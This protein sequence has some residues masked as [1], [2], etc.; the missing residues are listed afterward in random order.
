M[1][2]SDELKRASDE[3]EATRQLVE[4]LRAKI[5]A[6]ERRAKA[7]AEAVRLVD[8]WLP[9]FVKR[10]E[11]VEK[12]IPLHA[13]EILQRA[14]KAQLASI[15]KDAADL[16][17]QVDAVADAEDA[18][19]TAQKWRIRNALDSRIASARSLIAEQNKESVAITGPLAKANKALK[20][21]AKALAAGELD[22]A[23]ASLDD[24]EK[25]AQKARA[26]LAAVTHR[27]VMDTYEPG[28]SEAEAKIATARADLKTA[29]SSAPVQAQAQNKTGPSP[30]PS[31]TFPDSITPD[32]IKKH[33]ISDSIGGTTGA[34]LVE[35]DGVKYICKTTG[36]GQ[37]VTAEH[38]RNE[39]DADQAYRRAGIRVPDCR[40]YEVDGKTYKL[41]QYI[42]G[43]KTLGE[44]MKKATPA[45]KE[46]MR[47]QLAQGYALDAL[48]ANWD[49]LGTAQDN[50]LVDKDGNAWRI[51]N[52]S[53]FGFRAQGSKKKPEEWTKREWPDEWR[54]L[55]TSS[56]NKGVYDQLTA[57][58]IFHAFNRLD[59]DS[60]VRG[61]P[62]ET[63]KALAKPLEE[64]RQMGARCADYDRGGFLAEHTSDIL[65]RSYDM[66]KEGFR[67]EVPKKI[68]Q[69]HYGFCRRSGGGS[70]PQ[71]AFQKEF[72]AI[73]QA[74]ISINHHIGKGDFAAN[75]SS[76]QLALDSKSALLAAGEDP[77]A[78]KLLGF[79]KE[80]E[81]SQQNGFK[82]KIGQ[83]ELPKKA[84]PAGA[85][86]YKS[87]TDHL[88]DFASR[89]DKDV[90]GNPVPID[91]EKIGNC[92]GAQ[93]GSSWS[94]EATRLKILNL[95][96]RG[97]S[98]NPPP[99]DP[100]VWY[101]ANG[102][103]SPAWKSIAKDYAQDPA[104]ME[105]D[106]KA[107]R[108]WKSATTLLLENA[109]FDG[110]D[111]KA[112][113]MFVI[114]TEGDKETAGNPKDEI[115]T[116]FKM[117]SEESFSVFSSVCPVAGRNCFVRE[118]PYSRVSAIYFMDRNPQGHDMF[119]GDAE[120]E[121]GI[122]A[123]GLPTMFVGKLGRGVHPMDHK[124]KWDAK[125]TP[126]MA[127]SIRAR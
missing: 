32:E 6:A 50:V 51:D 75:Q 79:L 11:A 28:V 59:V 13:P 88:Y 124:A 64:M 61:L 48:F 99:Y 101:G 92:F 121:V 7:N 93:G 126:A 24:A 125:L 57:H 17:G 111:R 36:G 30:L 22:K 65:E 108:L 77:D 39:A 9:D 94:H 10:L 44:W 120:N 38:V 12:D 73:K 54:S 72:D 27:I 100:E 25:D 33:T 70:V 106:L 91:V 90:G 105:R 21:A 81:A 114:R 41:S 49:V 45:Q 14:N 85:P 115:S 84:A 117:G 8:T 52:G 123:T 5:D 18:V 71:T 20:A 2:L 96:M 58:D 3:A 86:K 98:W 95:A 55:R 87:L 67:E 4:Q 127:A 113:T 40:V 42:E 56:I 119:W 103:E 60:A 35:F 74:A 37:G 110:N 97:K 112:R 53:A 62:S 1:S 31:A 69:G 34:R 109:D 26:A 68:S 46:A 83:V 76:V 63:Q 19:R 47:A 102:S 66:S 80:I 116:S 122:D 104:K 43:G 82:T 78:K 16:A 29:R 89:C 23:E 118:V 15:E 107:L